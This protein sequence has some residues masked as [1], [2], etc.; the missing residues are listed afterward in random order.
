MT[1]S[2]NDVVTVT[3]NLAAIAAQL[4]NFGLATILG[5]SPGI[6]VGERR[7]LYTSASAIAA[8]LGNTSPEYLAAVDFF[9]QSPQPT[10]VWIGRWASSATAGLLRGAT[11]TAAQQLMTNFT[12]I[13]NGGMVITV[14]GTV[15][16]LTAMNFTGQTNLNG[17]ASVITTA[18]AGAATVTWD[19]VYSRF[20]VQSATTGINSVVTFASAGAGTD[21]SGLLGLT[22]AAGG[23][24]VAGIAAE[25]FTTAVN[26]FINQWVDWYSLTDATTVQPASSDVLSAAQAIQAATVARIYGTTSQ[27][28]NCLNGASTTDLAAILSG[29]NLSRTFLQYSSTDANAAA[30]IL[31]R[32]AT[33]N[34]QGVQTTLTIKFQ[35]EPGITAESLTETQAA[36]LKA[37]KC[38]VFTSYNNNTAIVQE[39]VMCNGYFIDEIFG[40]DWLQN[41]IQTG[42]YN[43]LYTAGTKVPQTN[44]GV[45]RLLGACE[46]VMDQADQNGL[47]APG[48]WTG[49]DIGPVTTGQTLPKGYLCFAQSVDDQDQA[50]REARIAPPITVLCKLAGAIHFANVAVNVNR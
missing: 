39:G 10:Q 27:D 26:Y 12:G 38:N 3:I 4:R 47:C 9:G 44:P 14:N 28:P 19:S 45:T 42:V 37:K 46:I 30:S 33:V 11:L 40:T 49:P 32:L 17:V 23:R 6:D 18:F 31:G 36:A 25:T 20:N 16:T 41:A 2:V 22:S 13:A 7:R 48:V 24:T 15:K 35:Q 8:D 50:S 43:R 5:D 1:L 34:F 21:V 29:A